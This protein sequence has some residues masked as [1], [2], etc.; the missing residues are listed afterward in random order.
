MKQ[1]TIDKKTL[2]KFVKSVPDWDELP[3]NLLLEGEPIEKG[4]FEIPYPTKEGILAFRN[5][6]KN[7]K[8]V[9]D[10]DC[11]NPCNIEHKHRSSYKPQKIDKECLK[12]RIQDIVFNSVANPP[13][14]YEITDVSN[15]SK[16]S[17]SSKYMDISDI[18]LYKKRL[19]FR[20]MEVWDII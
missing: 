16:E 17:F 10:K 11:N 1:F 3:D 7:K 9:E 12:K 19:L 15:S 2:L 8:P 18:E 6:H 20:L 5:Q 13:I 4:Y 14:S